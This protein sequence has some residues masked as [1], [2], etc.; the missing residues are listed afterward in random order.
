VAVKRISLAAGGDPI[1][2]ERATREALAGARLAH[3]A[4]VVLHEACAAE[5]AFYLI[6]ELVHGTLSRS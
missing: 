4:I 3:P 2:S 6:S 5:D 1:D